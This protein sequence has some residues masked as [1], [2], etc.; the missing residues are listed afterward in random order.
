MI[1]KQRN[2][3]AG[4]DGNPHLRTC[5]VEICLSPLELEAIHRH[6]QSAGF[7]QL[8][9][10]LRTLGTL[11]MLAENPNSTRKALVT[12]QGQLSRIGNNL[13]QIARKLNSG[14]PLD[15][16]IQLSLLKIVGLAETLL[17]EAREQ[18]GRP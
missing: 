16:E 6:R 18:R 13:N 4:S 1:E 12:A 15:D 10:Y 5:R 7:E 17:K 14:S 9:P 11:G 8:A 3:R 2:G